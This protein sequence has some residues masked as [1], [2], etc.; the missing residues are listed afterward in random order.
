MAALTIPHSRVAAPMVGC[1]DLAFRLLCRRHGADLCYTEMFFADRFVSDAAYRDAVFHS[2]LARDGADRP[3]VVQFGGNDAPT[4]V[5][6]ALLVQDWCDAVDLNLGC[7]QKRAREGVYGAFLSEREH[8]A[9]VFGIVRALRKALS[10]PV[11]CKI[12]LLPTLSQTIRFAR[13][14]QAAGC[15]LLAVHARQRGSETRRRAGPADLSAVRAIKRA[16]AIPVV[17]NGNVRRAAD[18]A[19][20]LLRTRADGAMVAEPLLR[21]PALLSAQAEERPS[22]ARRLELAQ[23]YLALAARH[24][25]PELS[26]AQAHVSWMLGRDGAGARLRYK[27]VCGL[28]DSQLLRAQLRGATSIGELSAMVATLQRLASAPPEAAHD[29]WGEEEAEEEAEAAEEA[30]EEAAT[31]A[32]QAVEE[33]MEEKAVEEVAVAAAAAEAESG[34]RASGC[35][36]QR[37][38]APPSVPRHTPGATRAYWT[39]GVIAFEHGAG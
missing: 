18:V 27:H 16:L 11:F 22:V 15:S 35:R 30:A 33:G 24:P 5:A 31:E 23:E 34:A 6:A 20:A 4:L 10:V 32:A 37:R 12:R 39:R 25:P 38:R 21:Y 14:L 29:R 7:P 28:A 36:V 9:R 26:Y 19:A 1:S 17:T 3:L 8:W 13:G 2:Q